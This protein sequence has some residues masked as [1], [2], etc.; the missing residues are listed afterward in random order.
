MGEWDVF[1]HCSRLQPPAPRAS[2]P[3]PALTGLTFSYL[4]PMKPRGL[5]ITKCTP[6]E[7]AWPFWSAKENTTSSCPVHSTGKYLRRARTA[8]YF[9][10]EYTE[11]PDLYPFPKWPLKRANALPTTIV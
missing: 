6:N 1:P 7:A 5:R 2:A 3:L 9:C 4:Q 8:R 10:G 11:H